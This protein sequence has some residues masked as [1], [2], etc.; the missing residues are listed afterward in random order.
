M[1]K[2]SVIVPIYNIESVVKRCV[3]SLV[4]QTYEN[5]EIILVDDGSRDHSTI[6]AKEYSKEY[7]NVKFIM[8]DNKGL[9]GA[10][11]TGLKEASG[12]LICF[13]DGDDYVSPDFIAKMVE[14]L[15]DADMVEP[16][17]MVVDEYGKLTDYN[18]HSPAD[19]NDYDFQNHPELLAKLA[20]YVRGN[21]YR[22]DLINGLEFPEGLVHEDIYYSSILFTRL[23]HVQYCPSAV[24]YYYMRRDSI[25]NLQNNKMFNMFDIMKRIKEYYDKNELHRYYFLLEKVYV[26]NFLVATMIKKA[27]KVEEKYKDERKRVCK[28]GLRYLDE[29]LPDYKKNPLIT[30]KEKLAVKALRFGLFRFVLWL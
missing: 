24:Y 11:N 4:K 26:R 5:L 6:I 30:W 21:L 12:D 28:E 14:A 16:L 17:N 23:A 18:Y 20:M 7:A 15:G 10:R 3:D 27:K 29:N 19:V 8:Q 25:M 22:R 9:S 1:E 13:V 2:V